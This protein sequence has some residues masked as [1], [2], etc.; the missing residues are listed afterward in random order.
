MINCVMSSAH[1][2]SS[3]PHAGLSYQELQVKDLYQLLRR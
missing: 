3:L 2:Y 1:E